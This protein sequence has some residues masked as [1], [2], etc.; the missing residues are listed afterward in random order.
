MPNDKY[1]VYTLMKFNIFDGQNPLEPQPCF[2]KS[3]F[4]VDFNTGKHKFITP[5]VTLKFLVS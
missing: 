1:I 2:S 5:T 4:C 3:N